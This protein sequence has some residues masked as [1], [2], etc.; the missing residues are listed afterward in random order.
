M[1]SDEELETALRCAHSL[2][3]SG[4]LTKTELA[5]T[6]WD[7]VA[8]RSDNPPPDPAALDRER[9]YRSVTKRR[10]AQS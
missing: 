3:R 6:I 10:P 4:R 9:R 1:T 2:I 5:N 7:L 8:A